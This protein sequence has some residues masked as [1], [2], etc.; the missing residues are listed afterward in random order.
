VFCFLVFMWLFLKS[1][2]NTYLIIGATI[3]TLVLLYMFGALTIPSFL[4]DFFLGTKDISDLDAVSSGRIDRNSAALRFISE[5]PM[6]GQLTTPY[7]FNWV[8]NY[9]LLK[10]SQYGLLGSFP[11]LFL[12]FYLI[13]TIIRKISKIREF[14]T[15]HFG[16]M[17]MII[18]ITISLFEPSFPYGPGS[19]QAIVYFMFGYSLKNA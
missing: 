6:F 3:I 2:K 17:V 10:V 15:E 19:V 8:H 12:Y 4:H 11:L 5:Y 13:W 7:Y 16:Y 14:G 18:P 9:V 1:K